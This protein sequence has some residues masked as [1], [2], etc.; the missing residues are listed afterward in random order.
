MSNRRMRKRISHTS[1]IARH[2]GNVWASLA[3]RPLQAC[4]IG[5]LSVAATWAVLTKSLPYAL[6]P[7][8]PDTALALNPNN[9]AALLVKA[10]E[11]R[12][13]LVALSSVEREKANEGEGERGDSQADTLS[14][15]PKAH[16]SEDAA[17]PFGEREVLRSAI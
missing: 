2:P 14:H 6:A 11:L 16:A 3:A 9:P 5:I 8:R 12:A 1:A 10:Q 17:E 4:L 7:T 15:L 13:K